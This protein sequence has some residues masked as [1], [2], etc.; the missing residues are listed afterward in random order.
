MFVLTSVG[1]VGCLVPIPIGA[2][3]FGSASRGD[4]QAEVVCASRRGSAVKRRF[5]YR[6]WA[7]IRID[8]HELQAAVDTYAS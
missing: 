1:V 5:S 8:S 4:K 3:P 7:Q 2:A 6:R